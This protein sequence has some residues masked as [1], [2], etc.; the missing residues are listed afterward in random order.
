MIFSRHPWVGDRP[1]A[2]KK[3]RLDF[4]SRI[5]EVD[6][7]GDLDLDSYEFKI[8][9]EIIADKAMSLHFA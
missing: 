2:L 7:S 5:P 1:I 8:V 9:S 3:E 6:E 4:K